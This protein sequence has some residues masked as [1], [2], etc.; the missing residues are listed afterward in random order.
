[1]RAA[2]RVTA[3]A[4][5]ALALGPGAGPAGAASAPA[6][7]YRPG[8]A[9]HFA[10]VNRPVVA[11]SR[12]TAAAHALGRLTLR[13]QDRTDELVGVLAQRRAGGRTWLR[14]QL[15]LRPTG[16][17]GWIPRD[18]VGEI[19]ATDLWL[20]ID[21][22]ALRARLIRGGRVVWSAPVGVGRAATPTPAGR[23]YVRDRITPKDPRGL[24][25]PVAFGTSAMSRVLT[26]WPGGGV[27]GIHGTDAPGLLPGRVSHGCVRLRNADIRALDAL[28][29]VGTPV[30]IS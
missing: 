2:L 13:T 20:R 23:F 8:H 11:R 17:T 10:F 30:T 28:L 9:A 25:G 12:P 3:V 15:P 29:E 27:I 4:A 14:V 1:M 18:A 6:E 26:D 21:R 16:S 7:L 24:Y 19:R 22:R 5:G